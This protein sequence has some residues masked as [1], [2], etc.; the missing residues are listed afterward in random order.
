[1]VE[2]RLG[3]EAKKGTFIIHGGVS[4]D[5][6]TDPGMGTGTLGMGHKPWD[7][8]MDRQPLLRLTQGGL[9]CHE[10]PRAQPS[11]RSKGK[12]VAGLTRTRGHRQHSQRAEPPVPHPQPPHLSPNVGSRGEAAPA[13]GPERS[14]PCAEFTFFGPGSLRQNS[15][16]LTAPGQRSQQGSSSSA[17]FKCKFQL[18]P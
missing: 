10:C 4:W 17:A 6:D 9:G 5:W 3:K 2:N 1:M 18:P 11:S 8:D 7:R 14:Q 15:F 16:P 12:P 13:G